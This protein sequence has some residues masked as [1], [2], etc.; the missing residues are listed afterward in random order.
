LGSI[1]ASKLADFVVYEKDWLNS[2][3]VSD[4]EILQ[5]RPLATIVGGKVEYGKL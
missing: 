2:G 3:V 4:L 1:T 5:Q